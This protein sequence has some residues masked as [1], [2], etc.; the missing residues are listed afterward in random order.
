LGY[1]INLSVDSI[2][3]KAFLFVEHC[4]G[5]DT[6]K[7]LQGGYQILLIEINMV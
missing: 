6:T 4:D 7:K 2:Y 5:R 1:V 3:D